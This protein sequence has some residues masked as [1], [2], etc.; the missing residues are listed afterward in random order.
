MVISKLHIIMSIGISSLTPN[1]YVKVINV[2]CLEL[3]S[4][5]LF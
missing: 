5:L 3:Y 2:F 1:I 4:L